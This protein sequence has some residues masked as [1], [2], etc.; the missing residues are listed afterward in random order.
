MHVRKG[1]SKE[2]MPDAPSSSSHRQFHRYA[3]HSTERALEAVTDLHTNVQNSITTQQTD[4]T[5]TST[6]KHVDKENVVYVHRRI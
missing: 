6:D 2:H 1:D 3:P 5:Q 4:P